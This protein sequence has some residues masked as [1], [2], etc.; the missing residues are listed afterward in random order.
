MKG[1]TM[2]QK[3]THCIDCGKEKPTPG[4]QRSPRCNA[5][6]GEHKRRGD[7]PYYTH[8]V[9][10]GQKKPLGTSRRHPRCTECGYKHLTNRPFFDTCQECGTAKDRNK[11]RLCHSCAGKA[12]WDES[13]R[14]AV[15]YP[16]CQECGEEK[17]DTTSPLCH[18]CSTRQ[19]WDD[20][21]RIRTLYDTC[22]ECGEPKPETASELCLSCAGIKRMLEQ[23]GNEDKEYPI[24]W[25]NTLKERIR[26]REG[27]RCALC[28][29]TKA[30]N[31]RKLDVHHIDE[32]KHNLAPEN[33]VALCASCHG[34]TRWQQDFY[35]EVFTKYRGRVP[36][37]DWQHR[38]VVM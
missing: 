26:D 1:E 25:C 28:G 8:C 29:K 21:G 3:Y 18:S 32:D 23:F 30:E 35:Y 7:R 37:Q 20:R 34:K 12:R 16:H 38:A 14:R 4:Q 24:G 33:L 11:S 17:A 5:C 10:C 13:G 22:Q 15:T 9:D 2:P 6:A 36:K 19:S 27:R 31:G